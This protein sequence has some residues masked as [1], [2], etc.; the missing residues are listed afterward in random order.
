MK[1][2]LLL[3]ALALPLVAQTP[4]YTATKTTTLSS[5]AEAITIQAPGAAGT[6]P[7]KL[8]TLTGASVNCSVACTV[9]VE[10]DGTA[11]T[12]TALTVSPL[13]YHYPAAQAVAFSASNVG[14]ATATL[15]SYPIVAGAT[16]LIDLSTKQLLSGGDNL[17]IR[18]NSITGTV[19]INFAWTEK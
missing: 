18:T 10:R 13:D 9:T 12:T 1:R 5:A 17:T 8:I 14:S 2:L 4:S 6:R 11:A 16:V 3:L 15:A 7:T 19:V